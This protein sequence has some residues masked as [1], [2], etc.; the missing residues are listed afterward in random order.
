MNIGN[1][2]ESSGAA[3]KPICTLK[4]KR[5]SKTPFLKSTHLPSAVAVKLEMQLPFTYSVLAQIMMI[6]KAMILN[7]ISANG[8]V[9]AN[10]GR[11]RL[12]IL[13]LHSGA[14]SVM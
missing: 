2:N 1:A 13:F 10:N 14:V 6:L 3:V 7:N 8:E 11:S 9:Y 12:F 4:H 5:I